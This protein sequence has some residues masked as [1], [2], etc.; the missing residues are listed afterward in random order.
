MNEEPP[1]RLVDAVHA[2]EAAQRLFEVVRQVLVAR[3]PAT[4]DVRHI[5]AT[6]VPDCLAKGDL[7]I[8]V[9][10]PGGDFADA[11]TALASPARNEGSIRTEGFS[12]FEDVASSPH[13]GVQLATIDGPLDFFHLFVKALQQSPKL[14]AEYNS[15]KRR[16]DGVNTASSGK[17]KMLSWSKCWL[18]P[19]LANDGTRRR[20]AAPQRNVG[21]QRRVRRSAPTTGTLTRTCLRCGTR[22]RRNSRYT[23]SRTSANA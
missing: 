9:R 3:L 22:L 17:P 10:I 23:R 5:G 20:F 16:H 7:D 13:L 2:R 12:T 15:L 14:V 19:K 18:P 8:V 4:A 1:F 11:D 6:A 21:C